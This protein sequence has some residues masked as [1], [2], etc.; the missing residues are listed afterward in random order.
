MAATLPTSDQRSAVSP[1]DD[2]DPSALLFTSAL[3]P[4]NA[5][6]SANE[7][8]LPL[9]VHIAPLAHTLEPQ[10][11][12]ALRCEAKSCLAYANKFCAL[13]ENSWRCVL[14][15]R[16]NRFGAGLTRDAL[17][18]QAEFTSEAVEYSLP[19]LGM[20]P[21]RLV[22][23]AVD[24]NLSKEALRDLQ[25]AV[26][27]ILPQLPA[28][29][30]LGL[31]TFGRAVGVYMLAECDGAEAVMFDAEPLPEEEAA[32]L[33]SQT[34]HFVGPKYATADHL[35]T[36]LSAL[37][38]PPPLPAA[39]ATYRTACSLPVETHRCMGS[40]LEIARQI[41]L[42]LSIQTPAHVDVIVTLCGPNNKG[43][44]ALPDATSRGA[45][46]ERQAACAAL[47]SLGLRLCRANVAAHVQCV[48]SHAF[49]AGVLRGMLLPCGG[50][51]L[52]EREPDSPAVGGA[53]SSAA[54]LT[55]NLTSILCR[56][57]HASIGAGGGAGGALSIRCT[58]GLL[59]AAVVGAAAPYDDADG[60]DAEHGVCF[61]GTLHHRTRLSVALEL[62]GAVEARD[63]HAVVQ[64]ALRYASEYGERRLRTLTAR[65][66]LTDSEAELLA[67]VRV[68]AATDLLAK[69]LLLQA[70]K[71]ALQPDTV[72]Q[73]VQ[74]QLELGIDETAA[75]LVQSYGSAVEKV[76]PGW[77]WNTRV[78]VGYDV[79]EK[80]YGLLAGLYRLRRSGVTRPLGD[81]DAAEVLRLLL[82]TAP[83]EATSLLIAPRLLG[84]DETTGRTLRSVP[85]VDLALTREAV[86][87]LDAHTDLFVWRASSVEENDGRCSELERQARAAALSRFPA[88][89][90]LTF[91]EATSAERWLL[92]RLEPSRR[93]PPDIQA[94]IMPE[95]STILDDTRQK[96]M[97]R[98]GHT[99]DLSLWEWGKSCGVL[100]VLP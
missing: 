39:L 89:N 21:P 17:R 70:S 7:S 51:L 43:L 30:Y 98:L 57:P 80:L 94:A 56:S 86:L 82:L 54:R 3:L 75:A 38:P 48:G 36:C 53:L 19:S 20:L 68:A 55:A 42:G 22:V 11:R 61:V 93:D 10:Y 16:S 18:Q 6:L 91:S 25:Q 99:D 83:L 45:E 14:C 60:D 78:T 29:T 90:V 81:S 44:G 71:R 31:L 46:R 8:G 74:R 85:A 77:L 28:E 88:A 27:T 32:S 65:V 5:Q 72:S 63:G 95:L 67:S 59:A 49:D 47:R 92:C 87:L 13:E 35:L 69:Q 37:E 2:S 26:R 4:A 52:L 84:V 33:R 64:V 96:I 1:V 97:E 73:S 66:P 62:E 79:N 23:F 41:A 50:S 34:S 9:G 12:E 40:A 58:R 100:T 15:G 24:D 76:T